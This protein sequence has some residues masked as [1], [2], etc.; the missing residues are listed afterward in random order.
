MYVIAL[1]TH[2]H[3]HLIIISFITYSRQNIMTIGVE[4]FVVSRV[5]VL[6]FAIPPHSLD[7]IKA[8]KSKLP[9]YT[10]KHTS[11]IN[12]ATLHNCPYIL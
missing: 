10:L 11:V 2:V 1:D 12:S 8:F 7:E 4:S 6:F 3:T 9:D 5:L